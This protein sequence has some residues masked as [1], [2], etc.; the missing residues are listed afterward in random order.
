MPQ[1]RRKTPF[2]GKAKKD[3]L[4]AKKQIK[5]GSQKSTYLL[6]PP[7]EPEESSS[8]V[9]KIN[10]QPSR[11]G[12]SKPN[13]YALQF[14]KESNEEIMMRKELACQSL[15]HKGE[16]DLEIDGKDYF[17][18]A[19]DFPKRPPWNF[20]LSKEKLEAQE[21]RYFTVRKKYHLL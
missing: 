15:E 17:D 20:E 5:H 16:I 4:K 10:Y 2:S 18:K 8:A 9:H 12:S 11:G 19:L 14:F 7:G 13:R 21:Q 3:Q 6:K 1:G